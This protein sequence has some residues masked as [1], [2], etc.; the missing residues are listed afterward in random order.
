MA[1]HRM[2]LGF[3]DFGARKEARGSLYFVR[4]ANGRGRSLLRTGLGGRDV[5]LSNPVSFVRACDVISGEP[6][7]SMAW[8]ISSLNVRCTVQRRR[9]SVFLPSGDCVAR[10][11]LV[12]QFRTPHELVHGMV[13]AMTFDWLGSGD[14][15]PMESEGRAEYKRKT[16]RDVPAPG[17]RA[18]WWLPSS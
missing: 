6:V 15:E 14:V 17:F 16:S 10:G 12:D 1:S 2:E 8:A 4:L 7:V 18:D 3:L 13:L 9:W 11:R 5:R